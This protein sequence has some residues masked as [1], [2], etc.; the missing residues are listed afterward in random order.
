MAVYLNPILFK[1]VQFGTP[2]RLP[3]NEVYV[4]MRY[5]FRSESEDIEGNRVNGK[6]HKQKTDFILLFSALFASCI[7][8]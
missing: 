7:I 5:G 1:L 4:V 2:C 8:N 6:R 3:F